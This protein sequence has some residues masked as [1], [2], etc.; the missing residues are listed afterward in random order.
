MNVILVRPPRLLL[1]R[2]ESRL[3]RT[4]KLKTPV[5]NSYRV[6]LHSTNVVAMKSLL[7]K[8]PSSN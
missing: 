2:I 6:K 4:R 1:R 5:V 8:Q 3:P 7:G